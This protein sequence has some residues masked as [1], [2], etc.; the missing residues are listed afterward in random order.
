[1]TRAGRIVPLTPKAFETLLVLV[2][3]R[4]EVVSRRDL[5][6]AVWPDTHVVEGTLNSNIFALRRVLGESE[7]GDVFIAT[8]PRRG[9]RFI[10]NVREVN[11]ALGPDSAMH[12]A[13][14]VFP[15][16]LI[17]G[18]AQDGAFG[19][20]IVT[21]LVTRLSRLPGVSLRR[22]SAVLH[23]ANLESNP[24]EIAG[25][26]AVDIFIE[27]SIQRA[28]DRVRVNLQL[29]RVEDGATLWAD[30]FDESLEDIFF[31]ED[32]I[33]TR[34]SLAISARL[35]RE[36]QDSGLRVP[37]SGDERGIQRMEDGG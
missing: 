13:L 20:G 34:A 3:Q 24:E 12:T 30:S 27:G 37:D 18:E 28:V 1:L 23:Y 19:A 5:I 15:L 32:S 10:A 8:V 31:A 26:L 9:Y 7:R 6:R 17:G 25:Q 33:S 11:C 35:A 36:V 14:A 2:E 16:T 4:G 22:P 21:A 29:V